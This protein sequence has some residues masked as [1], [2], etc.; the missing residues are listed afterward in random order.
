MTAKNDWR[1]TTTESGRRPESG[2]R[3]FKRPQN[4]KR[5][6]GTG[7]IL[8]SQDSPSCQYR[9]C[10]AFASQPPSSSPTLEFVVELGSNVGWSRGLCR[11]QSL[12]LATGWPCLHSSVPEHEPETGTQL[13]CLRPIE[14]QVY[15]FSLSGSDRSRRKS[16]TAAEAV[17]PFT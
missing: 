11:G 15:S 14:S 1:V 2:D 13:V 12:C 5:E 9:T 3:A 8:V 7:P 16:S 4:K 10:P 6:S 17:N